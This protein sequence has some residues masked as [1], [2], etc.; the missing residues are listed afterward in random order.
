MVQTMFDDRNLPQYLLRHILGTC[1][2]SY[3]ILCLQVKELVDGVCN[4]EEEF[5]EL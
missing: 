2:G 4:L 5:V 3:V 1:P